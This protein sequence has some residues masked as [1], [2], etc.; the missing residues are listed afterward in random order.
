MPKGSFRRPRYGFFALFLAFLLGAWAGLSPAI[1]T[2]QN[3]LILL[4]LVFLRLPWFY[5]FGTAVITWF[6]AAFLIDPALGRVGEFLLSEPALGGLWTSAYQ[7]PLV[8]LTRFN[9][10]MVLGA[11]AIGLCLIPLWGALA[12]KFRRA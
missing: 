10:S 5:L 11:F 7:L 12:W 6:L 1:F 9:N 8:P 2:L 4:C 3:F